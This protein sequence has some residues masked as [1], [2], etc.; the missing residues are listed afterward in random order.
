MKLLAKL[1]GML[2][3]AGMLARMGIERIETG[4]VW[5]PTRKQ[6]FED[7]HPFYRELRERD[8]IHRSR[9]AEGYVLSRYEDVLAVLSDK[10]FSADERH[11]RRWNRLLRRRRL[12]GLGDPY[13]DGRATMLRADPPDHTRVRGLVSKAFTPRAVEAMRGRIENLVDELL[14]PLA[15][16]NRTELVTDFAA[17]LPVVV[18]AEMLGVPAED[19]EQFRRW[20]DEIVRTL[21]DGTME[22]VLASEAAMEE[23]G[24][25]FREKANE[26]RTA[27]RD[28]LL[29]GLVA[30]EEEGQH[31]TEMELLGTLVLL[32]VAGNE[33]TTKLIANS[34]IALLRNP[35]Q[36]AL[37][38]EEPKRIAG[39]IDELLRYDGPVQLTSRMITED[40][41]FRGTPLK[42]GGQVVLLIAAANRDPAQF[43]HADRLDVTREDVRHLSFGH[44]IHFCLGAQLA[45]L[46]AALALEGLIR[47]FPDLRF[48][49]EK[50][51]WG[52]NTVLRGPKSLPLLL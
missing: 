8:P 10:T 17:P 33:T 46:E 15:R 2:F 49:A 35:E 43:E 25:Y 32:L 12:M 27:P 42:K 18:I 39:A 28:D 48:T 22:D 14:A 34:V 47:R 31:L 40:R 41:E 20:S 21:G 44:G 3:S 36:L 30:A 23:L 1:D 7:P 9:P 45:R 26:R 4:M 11:L 13:E 5:N 50:I 24:E 38:R 16:A 29:S 51:E 6:M 37:L 52:R 19:R